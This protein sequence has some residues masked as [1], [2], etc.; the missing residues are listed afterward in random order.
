[1][2]SALDGVFVGVVFRRL[3]VGVCGDGD[4]SISFC[5]VWQR[6]ALSILWRSARSWEKDVSSREAL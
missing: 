4:G 3:E 5:I 6:L 1:V 2:R